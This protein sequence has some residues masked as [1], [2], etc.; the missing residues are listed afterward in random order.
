ME[1]IIVTFI[2]VAILYSSIAKIRK[3]KKKGVKCIGCPHGGTSK[4]NCGC[5]KVI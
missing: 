2:I 5:D 3:E 4:G 1:N